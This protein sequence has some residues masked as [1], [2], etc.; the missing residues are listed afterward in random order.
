MARIPDF[1]LSQA[2]AELTE[3]L[4]KRPAPLLNYY[5]MLAHGGSVAV[6]FLQLGGAILHRS[7]I[8]PR[9]RELVILRTGAHC[10]SEYEICQHKRIASSVGVPDAK[11]AA[12]VDLDLPLQ[13]GALDATEVLLLRFTDELVRDVKASQGTFSRM[14]DAFPYKQVLEVVLTTGFYMAVSRFLETFEVDIED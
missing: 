4:A 14:C 7:E 9:L 2:S 6:G 12:A 1:D 13:P 5:R 10:R 3:E 8:D 11:I